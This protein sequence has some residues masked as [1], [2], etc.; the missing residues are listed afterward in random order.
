MDLSGVDVGLRHTHRGDLGRGED[1]RA[2][3]GQVEGLEGLAQGMPHGD[4][5]LHGCHGCQGEDTGAV[6]GSIDARHTGA[7]NLVNGDV[8]TR[9]DGN[10]DLL[11]AEVRAV[12]R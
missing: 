6:S 5:P 10:T 11:Q 2:H 4:A 1:I 3:Q 12:R 9:T 7:R 8:T